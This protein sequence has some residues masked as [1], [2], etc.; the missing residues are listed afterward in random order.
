MKTVFEKDLTSVCRKQKPCEH[1][2]CNYPFGECQEYCFSKKDDFLETLKNK[3]FS[4]GN[5]TRIMFLFY[6]SMVIIKVLIILVI[7]F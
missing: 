7:F 4:S 5:L 6:F 2:L 1:F 3:R